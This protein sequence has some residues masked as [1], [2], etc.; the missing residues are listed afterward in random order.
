MQY[1]SPP[2][3]PTDSNTGTANSVPEGAANGTSVG[4]TASSTDLNG[5]AGGV[6][7]I[8][9]LTDNAGGRFAINAT[10]G[11]VTVANGTLLN[12]EAATSH[13]ITEQASDG[14]G[15]T[16]SETF[17]IQVTNVNEAPVL[18]QPANQPDHR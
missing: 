7:V 15:G 18:A 6:G 11:V 10:T 14:A 12:Y 8:Y 16:S 13:T 3:E 5:R 1:N 2:T 17:T 9:S 4:I